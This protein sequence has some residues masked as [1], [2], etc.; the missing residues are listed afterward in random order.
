MRFVYGLSCIAL[1]L[2]SSVGFSYEDTF[3]LPK[4]VFRTYLVGTY[5]EVEGSFDE[6]SEDEILASG[7]NFNLAPNQIVAPGSPSEALY[8]NLNATQAGLG[9]TL[10]SN[11][12]ATDVETNFSQATVALEYGLTKKLSV[13]VI[14]PYLHIDTA[15]DF[16]TSNKSD[17]VIAAVSGT[18]LEGPVRQAA[19]S[20][21]QD[22]M[23]NQMFT[24]RGYEVPGDTVSQ[25][26]GDIEVGGKYRF[27]QAGD[28]TMATKFGFRLPTTSHEADRANLMDQSTGDG[29]LDMQ[30][31]LI[32]QYMVLPSL[33]VAMSV[34]GNMQLSDKVTR[35]AHKR[36]AS[37]GS[38]P[39]LNDPALSEYMTRD[40]GDYFEVQVG[41]TYN[42]WKE[43]LSV[44]G[45]YYYRTKQKDDYSGSKGLDYSSLEANTDSQTHRY[46][47]ALS[48]STIKDYS[49]KKFFVPLEF[50]VNY[51]DV[52][53]GVNA[54]NSQYV[55]GK[56]KVYF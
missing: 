35:S 39:N 24:S 21:S 23:E 56:L 40:L 29:Q 38:L 52:F 47:V 53:A 55:T 37:D 5:G 13:G 50:E 54:T 4:G 11:Q 9:D 3:V 48:Y 2:T 7:L 19:Q 46:E 45:S 41:S 26:L 32:S 14:V 10:F 44:S 30:A 27:V 28:F 17:E 15:S 20:L 12:V 36:G 51:S 18:P 16:S 1:L 6:N 25:G 43:R 22:A 31:Y 49:R 33:K 34:T 8:N 42:F